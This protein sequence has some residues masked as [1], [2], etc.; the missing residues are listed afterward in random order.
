MS[1][2]DAHLSKGYFPSE[3]PPSFHTRLFGS[4]VSANKAAVPNQFGKAR[5]AKL[6]SFSL[7][8]AGNHRFRRRLSLVNPQHF[9]RLSEEIA[10][11]WK[12][13]RQAARSVQI[14]K[15][16][17]VFVSTRSRAITPMFFKEAH[18]SGHKNVQ[19]PNSFSELTFQI[20]ITRFI[21]I[22]YHGRCIQKLRLNIIVAILSSETGWIH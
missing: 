9:F 13:L 19:E 7:A 11:S 14:G 2:I 3:L 1:L 21:P 8:R 16:S 20:S 12:S 5:T 18:P 4:L 15:S 10:T 6:C 17:P 22:Q